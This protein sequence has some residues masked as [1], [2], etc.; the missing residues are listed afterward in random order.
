MVHIEYA[1]THVYVPVVLYIYYNTLYY[2]CIIIIIYYYYIILLGSQ[3]CSTKSYEHK[4]T[5]GKEP[6]ASN[7][8][9]DTTMK[10]SDVVVDGDVEMPDKTS[11]AETEAVDE[12]ENEG[13]ESLGEHPT[14]KSHKV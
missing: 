9:L 10:V 1:N 11:P 13:G 2:Y 6:K 14:T 7:Q 4:P 8:R 5:I 12:T 3:P